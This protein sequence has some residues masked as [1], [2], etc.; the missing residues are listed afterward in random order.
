MSPDEPRVVS[1]VASGTTVGLVVAIALVVAVVS[2]LAV[3]PVVELSTDGVYSAI[4]VKAG[5][6]QLSLLE[7]NFESTRR[8][9][10]M[11][12]SIGALAPDVT[13]LLAPEVEITRDYLVGLGDVDQVSRLTTR[14]SLPP[15]VVADLDQYVVAA[16]DDDTVGR[17][18]LLLDEGGRAATELVLVP[19][20]D[21]VRIV[22]RRLLDERGVEVGP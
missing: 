19:V 14:P 17:W 1:P 20:G 9:V 2:N 21:V 22:D 5:H 18:E 15:E 8:R 7:E 4:E 11:E 10:L 12:V 16:G 13:A 3:L 6:D